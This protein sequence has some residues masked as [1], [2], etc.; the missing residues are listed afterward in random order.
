MKKRE[1][2]K[3]KKYLELSIMKRELIDFFMEFLTKKILER[4]RKS[5]IFNG[6]FKKKVLEE[7][8]KSKYNIPGNKTHDN[9]R[10][11]INKNKNISL[12]RGKNFSNDI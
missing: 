5:T 11:N 7:I 2:K 8:K 9:K 3:T 1:N 12:I 4:L 6:T 10:L